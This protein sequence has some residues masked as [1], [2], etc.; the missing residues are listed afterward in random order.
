MFLD[1]IQQLFVCN[2]VKK[3]KGFRKNESIHFPKTL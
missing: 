1:V 3:K 2:I